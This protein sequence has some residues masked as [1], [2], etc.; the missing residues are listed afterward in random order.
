MCLIKRDGV[1]DLKG[2]IKEQSSHS[3]GSPLREIDD[4]WG[5]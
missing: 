5:Q 3:V 4:T 2:A 1:G